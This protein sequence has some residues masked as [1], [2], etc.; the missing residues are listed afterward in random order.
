MTVFS[1]L[2]SHSRV[3]RSP[4]ASSPNETLSE[5]APEKARLS[6]RTSWAMSEARAATVSRIFSVPATLTAIGESAFASCPLSVVVFTRESDQNTV[7]AAVR[8]VF[9]TN[10]AI[11]FYVP[12]LYRTEYSD[13]IRQIGCDME[14]CTIN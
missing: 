11:R 9:P 13:Y 7:P 6:A 1:P 8:G 5:D 4:S 3:R 14:K 10:R 12:E 2:M